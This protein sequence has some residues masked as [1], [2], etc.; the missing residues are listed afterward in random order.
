MEPQNTKFDYPAGYSQKDVE[1]ELA[2]LQRQREEL[3]KRLKSIISDSKRLNE[4]LK[5]GGRTES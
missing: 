5:Q 3:N 2:E 1:Q 4:E